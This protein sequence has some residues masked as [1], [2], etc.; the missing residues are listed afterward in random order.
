MMKNKRIK[1]MKKTLSFC[2]IIFSLGMFAQGNVVKGAV[3][4]EDGIPLPGVNV[5]QKTT[6]NGTVTDFDGNYSITMVQGEKTLVFSYIGYKTVERTVTTSSLNIVLATDS[7]AL[8]E[9]VIVGYG[10]QKKS[11]I[12]GAVEVVNAEELDDAVF[13]G[14]DQMLQGRAAGVQI[15]SASGEP[16]A[17]PRIRIRGNTSINANSNPLWVVDGVPLSTA[18]NFSPQEIES[19]E[20]LKDAAST[21]IYGARGAAGVILVKTKRGKEGSIMQI[22]GSVLT[23]ITNFGGGYDVISGNE[24]ATYRNEIATFRGAG[25][26]FPNGSGPENLQ[27]IDWTDQIFRSGLRQEY[28]LSATGG[29]ENMGYFVSTNYLGEDGILVNSDFERVALRA[30]LD[31]KGFNDKLQVN[32]STN[33]TRSENN[34]GIIGGGGFR[35]G[36]GGS[37]LNSLLAEPLV[38]S[39]DFAGSSSTGQLF[40]NPYIDVT[41]DFRNRVLTN[42][43]ATIQTSYKIFDNLT[44]I[45]GIS[46]NLRYSND[47]RF[48]PG[49][50]ARA[51]LDNGV[52]SLTSQRFEDFVVTNY[53]RY[54]D[55]FSEKHQLSV[56]G[57]IEYSKFN[58]WQQQSNG[59]GLSLTDLGVDD[60]SFADNQTISSLT[61]QSILQSGFLRAEY[62]FNDKYLVNGTIRADGSSVFAENNKWGYFPSFGVAWK[63]INEPFLEAQNIFSDLRLRA[64]WGQV[65]VQAIP[66]YNS[67]SVFGST[68][69]GDPRP[70][71]FSGIGNTLNAGLRPLRLANPNLQWETTESLNIGIDAGLFNNKVDLSSDFYVKKS[72]DLLQTIAIPAETGFSQALVNLGEIENRGFEIS[73]TVRPVTTDNFSWTSAANGT[74]NKSKV[75]DLGTNPR[76]I[77]GGTHLFQPGEEFGV[78]FGRKNDGLIQQSDFE[79][80]GAPSFPTLGPDNAI[81]QIK[82]QDLDGDGT[83][84]NPDPITNFD[85]DETVIGNPNPDFIF[86]WNNDFKYKNLTLNVFIQGSIGNDIMNISGALLHSGNAADGLDAINNQ[87]VRYFNNRFIPGINEHNDPRYPRSGSTTVPYAPLR[88]IVSDVW[89]EDGSYVRLKNITLRYRLPIKSISVEVFVTGTN[90]L[91]LTNY[92]GADP[93]VSQNVGSASLRQGIDLSPYPLTKQYSLG[94]NINF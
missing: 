6:N 82:Y 8:D 62:S 94:I 7:A 25:Q 81:G 1:K 64:S 80:S 43:L 92:S 74:F 56:L 34:G 61:T 68:F 89:I 9:V 47:N 29:G 26:P 30:N 19:F 83:I 4:S 55:V 46:A 69:T 16:G 40:A 21:A 23:T 31:F 27:D 14:V 17:A 52:S 51:R 12:T 22:Q 53:L 79:T 10:S 84:G 78:F 15:T 91:T 41:K 28:N 77:S 57:G 76:I 48:A 35:N 63:A 45:N 2:L 66:P 13:N 42:T 36:T 70:I 11:K 72:S 87:S 39:L 88:G 20:V 85:T 65:G 33:I 58:F 54:E 49:E 75:I 86:G 3:T 71:V 18:P 32:V 38:P 67:L 73:L 44:F 90:L 93:E 59:S 37:Y 24:Y 60:V 5:L 50:V